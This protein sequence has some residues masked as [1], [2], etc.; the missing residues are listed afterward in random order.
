MRLVTTSDYAYRW[1]VLPEIEHLFKKNLSKHSTREYMELCEHVGVS[2]EAMPPRVGQFSS[3]FKINL[4]AIQHIQLS[5]D[6]FTAKLLALQADNSRLTYE[7]RCSINETAVEAEMK[8]L[9]RDELNK[10][11][12]IVEVM[13]AEKQ[14]LRLELQKWEVTAMYLQNSTAKSHWRLNEIFSLMEKLKSEVST[15]SSEEEI[16]NMLSSDAWSIDL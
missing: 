3:V 10:L 15:V 5:K 7:L 14:Q 13:E 6:T 1:L 8:Q 2:F 12:G 9:A 4:T 11:R 16:G